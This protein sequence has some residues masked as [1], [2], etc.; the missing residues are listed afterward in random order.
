MSA[1][2]PKRTP[3]GQLTLLQALKRRAE[4]KLEGASRDLSYSCFPFGAPS[5]LKSWIRQWYKHAKWLLSQKSHFLIRRFVSYMTSDYFADW[6]LFCSSFFSVQNPQDVLYMYPGC[7][8][9]T[10]HLAQHLSRS[11]GWMEKSSGGEKNIF[12]SLSPLSP[13]LLS[14]ISLS[15]SLSTSPPSFS[16]PFF[17]CLSLS[18]SLPL[19]LSLSLSL[20]ISFILPSALS[21]TNSRLLFLVFG[22]FS[23]VCRFW[24]FLSRRCPTVILTDLDYRWVSHGVG[25]PANAIFVSAHC[26]G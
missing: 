8:S 13:L 15:P 25:W 23:P 1:P 21:L 22:F 9:F 5:S 16:L 18:L 2:A 12:V 11:A 20:S 10:V 7:A 26:Q 3:P 19:S 14:P 17:P 4:Q 6:N 24:W